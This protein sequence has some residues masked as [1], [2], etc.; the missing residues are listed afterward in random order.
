MKLFF[1][2]LFQKNSL[3]YG[4]DDINYF[5]N[6]LDVPKLSTDQIILCDVDLTEKDLY[7]YMKC[8]KIDK[9]PGNDG[10]TK[11]SGMILN[12]PLFLL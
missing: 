1:E 2:T 7:D 6:T 3:K 8:M 9:S 12:Q 4:A 5:L 10:L 11:K